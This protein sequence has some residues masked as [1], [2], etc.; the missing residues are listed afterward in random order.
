MSKFACSFLKKYGW[1]EGK[2]L[3]TN[4]EGMAEPIKIKIKRDLTGVGYD[5]AEQFS[6]CWWEDAFK[7][8]AANIVVENHYDGVK[9]AAKTEIVKPTK[10]MHFSYKHFVPKGVM[11]NGVVETKKDS[12]S[13]EEDSE[14]FHWTDDQL[15]NACAGR[16]AHKGARHGIKQSGKL[17]RLALH[18]KTFYT[19]YGLSKSKSSHLIKRKNNQ[20]TPEKN[21]RC[22]LSLGSD[23]ISI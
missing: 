6:K 18:D 16:T 7:N 11:V 22:K 4:E 3:G 2:G 12:S 8:A 1:T 9:I 20:K 13:S 17:T 15:L 10:A 5:N 21:K 19:K 14:N 23:K